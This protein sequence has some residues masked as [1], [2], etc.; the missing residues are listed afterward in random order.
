MLPAAEARETV[1]DLGTTR[2]PQEMDHGQG[3]T[4]ATETGTQVVTGL[5]DE[6][7]SETSRHLAEALTLQPT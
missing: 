5:P 6:V 7:A 3:P 2:G 1:E 4:P